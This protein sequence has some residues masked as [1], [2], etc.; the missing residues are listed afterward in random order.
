MEITDKMIDYIAALA[1]ME[2]SGEK[3]ENLKIDLE[4]MIN[5]MEILKELDL[6]DE[7]PLSHPFDNTDCTRADCTFPSMD[8][9]TLL[10]NAPV[11]KD[12]YFVVPKTVE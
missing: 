4:K 5:Y 3:A 10:A 8:R 7:N 2:I 12:G 11:K 1:K 6:T 9:D